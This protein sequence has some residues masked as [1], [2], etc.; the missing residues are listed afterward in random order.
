MIQGDENEQERLENLC[1]EARTS[2]SCTRSRLD[3][4]AVVFKH[5]TVL[6]PALSNPGEGQSGCWQ[7]GETV[8]DFVR[9]LPPVS[10]SAY[11]VDWIWVHNPYPQPQ[12]KSRP[13]EVDKFIIRG[14]ELL[15][16]SLQTRNEIGS[17]HQT[18]NK[19][20]AIR[21]LK[22]ESRLL[23]ERISDL[24]AQTN[25]IFGK[26]SICSCSSHRQC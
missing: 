1:E 3:L 16:R 15:A 5:R 18:K 13:P 19:S 25:V 24:A 12:G 7:L 20:L 21:H 10:T 4:N 26:V 9:R 23:Q 8:E 14:R 11:D 2:I 17:G 6:P 22:E